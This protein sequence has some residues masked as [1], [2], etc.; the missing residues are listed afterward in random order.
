FETGSLTK[1]FTALLLADMA[2]KGE[3]S[4]DDPAQKYLPEGATMPRRGGREI[5][6]RD[7]S[8]HV[9]GLP[10]L[11]DN[12]PYGDPA[13]P[14]ADYGEAELLVFLSSFRLPR[15]IGSQF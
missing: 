7:L 11:P 8:M 2:S 9:S 14:Y 13:D 10:R 12:M 3:V 4:L 1:L 5:T 15:D 6:L